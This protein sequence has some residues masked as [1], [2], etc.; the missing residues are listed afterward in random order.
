MRND[1]V[2]RRFSS[3]GADEVMS[4][5]ESGRLL[6]SE[7]LAS[8]HRTGV[9]AESLYE[10]HPVLANFVK[11]AGTGTFDFADESNGTQVFTILALSTYGAIDIVAWQPTTARIRS[12]LGRAFAL[13]EEQIYGPCLGQEPLPI[14]C[15]P[16]GWLRARRHGLVILRPDAANFHLACVPSIAPENAAHAE[17]L[18]RILRPRHAKTKIVMRHEQQAHGGSK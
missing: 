10:P 3:L 8:F 15:N 13:G 5:H 18:E 7:E 6:N 9:P 2:A 1:V 17:Q 12:W 16:W 11:A 4:A 14:W